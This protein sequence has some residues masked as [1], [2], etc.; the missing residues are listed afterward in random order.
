M[1]QTITYG[2]A[3]GALS[4][5]LFVALL[6]GLPL[7]FLLYLLTPLPAFMAGLIQ[8][9][10]A[11]GV[12]AGAAAVALLFAGPPALAATHVVGFGLPAWALLATAASAG[13]AVRR[14][15]G[16]GLVALAVLLAGT[17]GAANVLLLGA[18]VE[19][20]RSTLATVFEFYREQLGGMT[21]QAWPADQ[22]ALVL[23]LT[24]RIMPGIAAVSW[25]ALMLGNLWLAG[26]LAGSRR[27]DVGALVA[28]RAFRLPSWM[29]LTF[30]ASLLVAYFG[31]PYASL[32]ASAFAAAH[33]A[34]YAI[35]GLALVHRLT[36]GHRLRALILIALYL[37]LLLAG[38]YVV[39]VLITF[40]LAAPLFGLD[41]RLPTLSNN[42]PT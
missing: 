41:R 15:T 20:Y 33:G 34:G 13:D 35:E 5:L 17:F 30:M 16:P 26:R 28:L 7:A 25:L 32:L 12:A 27:R 3:A 8:G 2:L 42:T 40:A 18:D 9:P 1:G 4:A 24:T 38:Y 37:A 31:P 22:T 23:D 11:A 10:V 14:Q 19:T 39:F 21:G 29:T 6:T 36:F